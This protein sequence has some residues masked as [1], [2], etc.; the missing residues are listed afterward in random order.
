MEWP[1]GL[2]CFAGCD[3]V[4]VPESGRRRWSRWRVFAFCLGSCAVRELF[5]LSTRLS[6]MILLMGGL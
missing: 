3:G 6:I 1:T 2:Y 5:F 4:G